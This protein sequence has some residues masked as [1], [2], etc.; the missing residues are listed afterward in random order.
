MT[1][2]SAIAMLE[3]YPQP[4]ADAFVDNAVAFAS[5]IGAR[6]H[7]LVLRVDIPDVSNAFSRLLI[8]VPA[9]IRKAEAESRANGERLAGSLAAAAGKAGVEATGSEIID[10]QVRLGD[11]AAEAARYYDLSILGVPLREGH[12]QMLAEAV[13]FGTGRPTVLLPEAWGRRA[14]GHV[15][16]AWDGSRVAAR[17]VADAGFLL[18]RAEKA[19]ILTV[20]DEKPLPGED[21]G[22]RLAATL[23]RPGLAV[24][25]ARIMAEN[26]PIGDTLQDRALEFGA[27]ILVMGGYGHSRLRDFV[28]GGAT[29]GILDDPRMPVLLSH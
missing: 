22:E 27:D 3:T 25:V 7:G 12:S 23:R 24:E 14:M 1:S 16:I 28:L 8:D 2:L 11:A 26:G 15:A 20:F 17:A 5:G 13:V 21:I 9:M 19:T 10:E 6:L 29:R 18:S 4:S